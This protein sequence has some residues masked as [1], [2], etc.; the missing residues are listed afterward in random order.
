MRP[1]SRTLLCGLLCLALP[2]LAP[3]AELPRAKPEDVG[4]SADR[5]ARIDP[6]VRKMVDDKKTAGVVVAVARRGKLVELK[7]FGMM[8]VAAGKPM[9]EDTVFR[10]YSMSKPITTAAAMILYDEGKF[11]LDDPVATYLPE[12]K[13]LKV[14]QEDGE[15]V[16]L[17]RPVTM[18]DLMRH[19]AG[20]TYGSDPTPVDKLYRDKKVLDRNSSLEQMV[21]KLGTIPLRYQPGTHWHYS[22]SVDVLGRVVEVI[23][24]KPLDEFFAER[25]FKPLDMKDTAFYVPRDKLDRFAANYGPKKEG[26]LRAIDVPAQSA[27][28]QKPKMFSGGGGLVSTARDYL[29]FCQMMQNGGELDGRRILRAETVKL[30]TKNEL[31]AEA[32]RNQK[33]RGAG[34]GFGFS[35][36]VGKGGA[37]GAALGEYGWGGAASTHFWISPKDKLTVIVLQQYMP[38]QNR[39]EVELKPVIYG[40]ITDRAEARR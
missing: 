38:F 35:V 7:T 26:G 12:F 27:Y 16:E 8:D 37:G 5:L 33:D 2:P 18:A 14:Y 11:R 22:V 19:T 20:L 9:K 10:I 34:F 31:P 40:A 13:H 4:M 25:I 23:S 32:M 21:E 15:P 3:A 28:R 24:G 29:R 1:S 30:M 17:K 36:R 6:I 39:L